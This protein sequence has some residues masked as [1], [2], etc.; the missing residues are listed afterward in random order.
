M[1][2]Y[3]AKAE[4]ALA[5]LAESEEEFAQYKASHQAEDKRR[6]IV[7]AA[8]ILESPESSQSAKTAWAE[9]SQKYKEAVDD[10]ER[11]MEAFYLIDAKRRRAELTIEM[12]RSVNSSMKKGNI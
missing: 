7:R 6:Q 1:N 12:F 2:D 8:M 3:F 5:Y 4:K 10:W 11:M 9:A